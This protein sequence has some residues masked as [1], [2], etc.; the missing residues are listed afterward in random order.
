MVCWLH[1]W[2]VVSN[3]V[4]SVSQTKGCDFVFMIVCLFEFEQLEMVRRQL[5]SLVD[6]S[7]SSCF[8]FSGS[9]VS[10]Y[11]DIFHWF[12]HG[13]LDD[14]ASYRLR[15]IDYILFFAELN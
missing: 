8:I 12:L 9:F 2:L 5:S 3:G 6:L 4:L 13:S 1:L 14:T 11:N 7:F 15:T 10:P